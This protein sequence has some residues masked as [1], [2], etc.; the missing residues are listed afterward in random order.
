SRYRRTREPA[1]PA[2]WRNPSAGGSEV[3]PCSGVTRGSPAVRARSHVVVVLVVQHVADEQ[4]DGLASIVLPP[5]GGA[6]G[7][8]PDLAGLVH[9]RHGA[10]AGV[11]DDLAF[12][13]VDD[14][15]TVGVA[16]PRHDAAGLDGQL[17]EAELALLDIGRLLLEVDCREHRVGDAL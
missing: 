1:L 4:D 3:T 8:R 2:P 10:V 11:F 13:D 7:F 6:A 16:V 17:A 9:D 14:G 15:G 5:V 12:G